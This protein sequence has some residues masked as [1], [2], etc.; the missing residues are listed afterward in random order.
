MARWRQRDN[1][2]RFNDLAC[3]CQASKDPKWSTLLD[4]EPQLEI[5]VVVG[6]MG[7]SYEDWNGVF[8]PE[9]AASR[10]WLSQYARAFDTVEIDSTFYGTPRS[11]TIRSWVRST[12]DHFVFCSKVPKLITH[13][14]GMRDALEPLANFVGA[15]AAMGDK[16][17]PM[18]FQMPP[19]FTYDDLSALRALLPQL[20]RVGDPNARF[21]IE[22]RHI[23]LLTAEV[24][25]LLR[26]HNVALVA[27][28]YTRMPASVRPDG[29]FR[30]HSPHRQARRLRFSPGGGQG[31]LRKRAAMGL[32]AETS[33]EPV[34]A[35]MGLLQ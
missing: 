31:P 21:A 22:F 32:I 15:M 16:R 26:A 9:G 13:E 6:T 5:P 34:P 30:L 3:G 35:S 7:W 8:Y 11:A 10:D 27:A 20:G 4:G 28:D 24:F 18:L 14:L 23:S 19:S 29:R 25:A 12:P 2:I 33:S 1:V 17:G